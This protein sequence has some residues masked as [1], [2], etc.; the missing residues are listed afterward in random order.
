MFQ[1]F[2]WNSPRLLLSCFGEKRKI[3]QSKKKRGNGRLQMSS[4]CQPSFCTWR[5]NRLEA[6]FVFIELT[7]YVIKGPLRMTPSNTTQEQRGSRSHLG[8][9][10]A[11]RL[12]EE[13]WIQL[14][15]TSPV[16]I[17]VKLNYAMLIFKDTGSFTFQ[18]M[19]GG[20][21]RKLRA[22]V[23]RRLRAESCQLCGMK[24]IILAFHLIQSPSV[25]YAFR[26]AV[27]FV[28]IGPCYWC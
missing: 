24:V 21:K 2:W 13:K 22:I 7:L 10:Q 4:T 5:W 19:T 3:K 23:S 28:T 8:T 20:V 9:S 25:A 16:V 14:T 27:V 6:E 18:C 12:L 11:N 15:V 17:S 1:G 26:N